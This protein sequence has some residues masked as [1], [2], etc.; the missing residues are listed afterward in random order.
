LLEHEELFLRTP[1]RDPG[2]PFFEDWSLDK[3]LLPALKLDLLAV[4]FGVLT[5][6]TILGTSS[7]GIFSVSDLEANYRGMQFYRGLCDGP[8]PA[9]VRLERDEGAGHD[10]EAGDRAWR[11]VDLD[12]VGTTLVMPHSRCN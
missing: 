8:H 7:S 4:L 5:E 6:R 10:E 11:E 3:L 1:V 12:I 9:L 2:L